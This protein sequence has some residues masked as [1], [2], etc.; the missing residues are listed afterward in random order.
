LENL[1]Y[2]LDHIADIIELGINPRNN[3][4]REIELNHSNLRL[5]SKFAQ[6]AILIDLTGVI[7]GEVK[8]LDRTAEEINNDLD[9]PDL[10][11][12]TISAVPEYHSILKSGKTINN[13]HHASQRDTWIKKIK[14][15][16]DKLGEI[17]V[18]STKKR[19]DTLGEIKV[20]SFKKR[21]DTLEEIKI[22]DTLQ[23]EDS[24]AKYERD[25]KKMNI[26]DA[27]RQR[28]LEREKHFINSLNKL[29]SFYSLLDESNCLTDRNE[30]NLSKSVNS[31]VDNS[32]DLIDRDKYL[33][34]IDELNSSSFFAYSHVDDSNCLTDREKF[35]LGR[36]DQYM[37]A[38]D[39]I[40]LKNLISKRKQLLHDKRP[41][42]STK[43]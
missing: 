29:R 33:L 7:D 6:C 32:N 16:G 15:R 2:W 11:I 5:K 3:T 22:R 31:H 28:I 34:G 27:I 41:V 26:P 38:A 14:K 40:E 36:D 37:T 43:S 13:P 35:L 9:D 12:G 17:K 8:K 24:I 20:E 19:G 18:E 42:L 1:N 21:G 39:L 4:V 23:Q 30:L 25:L 10:V